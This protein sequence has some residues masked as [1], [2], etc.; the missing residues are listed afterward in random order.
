[1]LFGQRHICTGPGKVTGTINLRGQAGGGTA[2]VQLTMPK[3]QFG[4]GRKG[5]AWVQAIHVPVHLECG[6]GKRSHT[7]S[8]EA[9]GSHLLL[10]QQ[11]ALLG[12]SV[13]GSLVMAALTA[14]QQVNFLIFFPLER[15]G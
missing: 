14:E 12:Y 13:G 10:A 11:F 15:C 2:E 9:L 5:T 7:R 1:L 3:W 4:L 6:G 8:R